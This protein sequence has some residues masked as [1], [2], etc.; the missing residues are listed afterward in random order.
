MILA[1][2]HDDVIEW[3]HF[4]R[5]WPFVR[6]IHRSSVNSPHKGHWHGA[7]MLSMICLWTNSWVNNC[8]A[9]DLR[10][11]RAHYDVTVMLGFNSGTFLIPSVQN[12][13]CNPGF[14]AKLKSRYLNLRWL[15]SLLTY[16]YRLNYGIIT[17]G[18]IREVA[19]V[20]MHFIP[21]LRSQIARFLGATW[22]PPGSCR[23][24]LGPIL[25]PWTLL[26]GALSQNSH[27]IVDDVFKYIFLN[28]NL[29][30][31]EANLLE[32]VS[33][34][35]IDNTYVLANQVESHYLNQWW[36]SLYRRTCVPRP[37]SLRQLNYCDAVSQMRTSLAACR[38]LALDYNTHPKLLHVFEHK[39]KYVL[40]HAPYT[41]IVIFWHISNIPPMISESQ[42]CCNIATFCIIAIFVKYCY[43]TGSWLL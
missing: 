33:K 14:A 27:H 9:G 19:M 41:R 23:P 5:Y 42:I 17:I 35:P 12:A 18:V 22:G 30:I 28:E 25:A 3:K 20:W 24:Q 39:M 8:D 37:L 29:R 10:R 43:T 26:S 21:Y 2:L 16:L 15:V 11:H 40:I 4:P 34:N 38:E 1:A 6:G 31:L 32:F 7:F 13:C 36:H